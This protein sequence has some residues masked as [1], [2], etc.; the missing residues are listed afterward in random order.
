MRSSQQIR[1]S[2]LYAFILLGALLLILR[3]AF[4]QFAQ[5]SRYATL[6]LRNQ[7]SILPMV[8]SRGIIL[9]RNGVILA[10]NR[11]VYVLELMPERIKN[12][13]ETLAQLRL[14]LPDITDEEVESFNKQRKAH[15]SF[16]AIPLKLK[17]T[18]E[19]VA[20][21]ASQQYRFPGVSI[22]AQLL[23][24]YPMKD[25]MAHVLGYVGRINLQELKQVDSTQYQGTNFIGKSGI[26]KYYESILHGQVGYEQVETDVSGR[27][28]R[29]ISRQAPVTGEKLYLTLDAELQ[30][31]AYRAFEGMRGA[32]VVL[33]VR[34][35][36]VLALVSSPSFNP[37]AFVKGVSQKQYQAWLNATDRPLY[38]RAIRGLYPPAST[39][40]PFVALAGLENEVIGPM[41]SIYDPGWYRLPGIK[42]VYHDWRRTGHGIT[43]LRRA[44]MVSCDTY[45]YQLGNKLGINKLEDM[46][47]QFGFGQLTHIDLFE[48]VPGLVPSP[49]W[50]RQTQG[51]P[52]YPGDNL[53]TSIGQ[54][55]MLATP[56]QLAN[57]VSAM[58]QRGKHFRPHLLH[59]RILES[60]IIKSFK[61]V[62]EYPIVL[63]NTAYWDWV[64]EGMHS[65]ITQNEGTGYRFGRDAPYSVAGKTGTAQVFSLNPNDKKT[66]VG[67][68]PELRDH[69][70]FIAFAPVEEPEVAIAVLVENDVM[71]S[72]I[73][74]VI[75]DAYFK[76]NRP[77]IIENH[78]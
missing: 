55:S 36:D 11:P 48:E 21:F 42:H 40:K 60:G 38:H 18:Q 25:V 52:W 67:I 78:D 70:W 72:H 32:A 44:I 59:H 68:P 77:K 74:R 26:E 41:T 54:G 39:V 76:K 31:T 45:F 7:M 20:T 61:Q 33:Q 28:L 47:L 49:R 19:Q 62:E 2:I 50:K 34:S 65:V 14:L 37:N 57:A 16:V 17:L 9:D 46:L 22:K 1:L 69:S 30:E 51:L 63:K 73:A 24:Y 71:A 4:L 5:Y 3:L 53:I 13:S 27:T 56:L 12:M 23:R 8:P 35:G 10:E 58:A 15:R 66:P 64:I 29:V 6:S 75:L 43:N